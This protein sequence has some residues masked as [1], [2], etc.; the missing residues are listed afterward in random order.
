[1]SFHVPHRFRLRAGRF[2]ST[3]EI[4]NN[5]AFFV[6]TRPGQTPFTV[7]ASDGLLM[8]GDDA[9]LSGWEHVSVSLPTRCPSWEEMSRIKGLFWDAGDCVVQFHPPH[10][11]YVNNH[12]YCLHLWRAIATPFPMPPSILVGIVTSVPVKL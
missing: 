6:P 4:G 5:G 1:M 8:H 3:D 10:S 7:I 9:A 12:R 11:E 2:G